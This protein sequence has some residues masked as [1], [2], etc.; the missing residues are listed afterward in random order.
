MARFVIGDE[1]GNIKTLRYLPQPSSDLP[2]TQVTTVHRK[3]ENDVANPVQALA[4]AA[5]H[6]SPDSL[7]AASFADGSAFVSRLKP[8]DTLE[9]IHEWKE[10]RLQ[11][12]KG[13]KN[14]GL[15][16]TDTAVYTCT[17]NGALRW[18]SIAQFSESQSVSLPNRLFDWKLSTSTD[19]FAYGGDEVDVSV[20][21]VERA[22]QHTSEVVKS[23][24]SDSTSAG[25][26][27]RKRNDTLFP[28]EIWRAKNLPNDSLGLRQPIRITALEYLSSTA[29]CSQLL[30]GTAFGDVRRYDTRTARR[31]VADWKQIGKVGGINA[32]T[33]GLSE[34]QAFVSDHGSNLFCLDLRNGRIAYSYKGL[35]GAINS[36]ASSPTNIL[37]TSLDR[38]AR[39]HSVYPLP[40]I[41]GQQQGDKG[42]V[43]EKIYLKSTPVAAV[44]D[45]GTSSGAEEKQSEDLEGDD[46]DVWNE[47]NRVDDDDGGKPAKR[48][49]VK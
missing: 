10:S 23:P 37:S 34:N 3:R 36:I 5:Q 49:V 16:L 47:M 38:Y 20:W 24:A 39:I 28:G 32:I 13:H 41:E 25:S 12:K 30:A 15:A 44:W 43:L 18:T 2:H 22:F 17:S 6:S 29:S 1:L 48:R 4:T 40:E 31:P 9:V 45:K 8:D 42:E 19:F 33:K 7:L 14:I 46:D 11:K 26:K 35:S 27:K 21:N